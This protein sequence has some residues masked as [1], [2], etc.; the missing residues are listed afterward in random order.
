MSARKWWIIGAAV[1]A[2]V[3]AVAVLGVVKLTRHAP[4]DCD[5]VHEMVTYNTQFNASI[6][7]SASAG[8]PIGSSVADYQKWA[9]RLHEYAGQIH[10][11]KLTEP[12]N[13]VAGLADQMVAVVPRVRADSADT[14]V[15]P[16]QS[17]IDYSRIGH[18]FHDNFTKLEQACP[19]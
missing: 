12:A 4:S 8:D 6:K 2:V 3:V 9:A 7:Q 10:D 11:S 19:A 15:N 17:V 5:T 16:P 13:A 1:V 18:E 14:T